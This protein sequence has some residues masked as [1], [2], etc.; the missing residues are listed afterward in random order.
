[1]FADPLADREIQYPANFLQSVV[2]DT[3]LRTLAEPAMKTD[4]SA[5]K[6]SIALWTITIL[7]LCR[8]LGQ[9]GVYFL[10]IEWLPPFS[11]WYSGLLPY[12]Y[13]FPSQCLILL[14]M[15]KI[16]RDVFQQS[17]FFSDSEIKTA[18][19]IRWFS[20]IYAGGMLLRYAVTMYA[21][22]ERRWLGEGTIPVTFH[23]LL[24]LYLY[25][26]SGYLKKARNTY[27]V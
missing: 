2:D 15:L 10:E 4:Y 1:L 14:L 16:N 6:L 9:L 5:Q 20:Y 26:Y 24:A 22:P 17:G 7:F 25:L 8:V 23:I 19:I 18:M 21:Y 12:Q 13:L 11:H 27:A 3:L